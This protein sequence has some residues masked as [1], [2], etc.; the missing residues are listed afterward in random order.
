MA[1]T[2]RLGNLVSALIALET[3]RYRLRAPELLDALID[4]LHKQDDEELTAG[5]N[6]WEVQVLLPRRFRGVGVRA[7]A[8][9][10][11]GTDDLGRDR[12]GVD[13]RVG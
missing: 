5:F 11:G 4:L 2:F 13:R 7:A 3:T 9:A 8:A 6:E 12:S 1:P 10:R